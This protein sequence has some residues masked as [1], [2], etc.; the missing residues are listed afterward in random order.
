MYVENTRADYKVKLAHLVDLVSNSN[1][2]MGL[3]ETWCSS[4]HI[5][6]TTALIYCNVISPLFYG[7][8]HRPHPTDIRLPI[9]TISARVSKRVL[10]IYR[11]VDISGY[12]NR[13]P[14]VRGA[15]DPLRGQHNTN[16][17]GASF[18]EKL[19]VVKFIKHG[20]AILNG[21]FTA[22]NPL[23]VYN[24]NQAGRGLTTPGICPDYSAPSNIS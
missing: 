7:R 12:S 1:W 20:D 21:T 15:S 9:V 22:M 18:A 24:L 13:I 11:A 23:E 14:D 19:Q 6:E 3:C 5:E 4:L 10:D 17:F 16:N 2:E 8:Q